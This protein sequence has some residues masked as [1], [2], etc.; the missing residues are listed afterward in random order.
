[1]LSPPTDRLHKFL[2]IAGL[3][4]FVVGVTFPIDRYDQAVRQFIEAKAV[5]MDVSNKQLELST[6]LSKGS[7][8]GAEHERLQREIA[9]GLNKARTAG[10]LAEHAN[11][12]KTIWFVLGSFCT[13]GGLALALVGFRMW[14]KQ[15]VE[16]R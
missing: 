15:P 6:L 4:L 16:L 3:A 14:W 5:F 1:V 10:E 13:F 12:L 9:V 2:A 8:S 11:A 7:D